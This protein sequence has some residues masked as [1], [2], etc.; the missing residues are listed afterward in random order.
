MPGIRAW[1]GRLKDGAAAL[2]KRRAQV[3]ARNEAELLAERERAAEARRTRPRNPDPARAVP[4][5]VRVAAEACWR[6]LVLAAAL[7]VVMRVIGSVRLVVLA[8]AAALLITA[9]LEPTVA[10]LHRIGL[11]RGSP[12]PS[13]RSSGSSSWDW[14]A[15]SS[16]GRCS[17]TSTTCPSGSRRASTS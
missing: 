15:G 16:Y 10:R 3:Q 2:G 13:R 8:F 14:S 17:T 9:L 1:P 4:W 12:P 11:S 5:G 6:F 7:W